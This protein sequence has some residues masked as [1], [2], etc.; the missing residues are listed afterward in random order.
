LVSIGITNT[1]SIVANL[2]PVSSWGYG[3]VSFVSAWYHHGNFDKNFIVY[4]RFPLQKKLLAKYFVKGPTK[5]CYG[6]FFY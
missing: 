5:A 3:I 4:F 2:M 1:S 6:N